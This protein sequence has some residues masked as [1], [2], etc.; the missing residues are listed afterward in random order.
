MREWMWMYTGDE[1]ESPRQESG[2]PLMV[3]R[4]LR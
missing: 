4:K 1:K 2:A 3:E